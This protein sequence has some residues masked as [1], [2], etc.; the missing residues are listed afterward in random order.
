VVFRYNFDKKKYNIILYN[1]KGL[2]MKLKNIL[3]LFLLFIALGTKLYATPPVSIEMDKVNYTTE[4][5]PIVYLN[6]MLGDEEDWIA[7]YPKNSSNDWENVIYWDWTDGFINGSLSFER[8]PIGE[9]EARV[10]FKNS[11]R[12]E[13]KYAFNVLGSEAL[14]STD[15]NQYSVDEEINVHFEH[16]FGDTEDWI[17]I[18]PKGSSN[19]WENVLDWE[20]T[21]GLKN[22]QIAFDELPLCQYEV[23]TFYR[24]SYSVEAKYQFNVEPK[25]SIQTDKS[26]YITEEKIHITFEQMFG[27]SQDWIALY[28]KGSSNDWDNVISWN[29]TNGEKNGQLDFDVPPVGQYEIRA[30]F[31]NSYRVESN[32]SITVIDTENLLSIE[33]DKDEYNVSENIV[34]NFEYMQGDINQDWIAIYPKDSA[35]DGSNILLWAYTDGSVNG[36]VTLGKLPMGEYEARAFFHNSYNLEATYTFKVKHQEGNS[37]IYEDGENG[38]SPNWIHQAGD[39]APIH[40]DNDGFNSN[41]ALALV[42]QWVYNTTNLALYYL[43]LNNTTQKI[44]EMDIGGLSN[45]HIPNK[46]ANQIGYMSHFAIGVSIHTTDGKRRM[47]WDSFLNH[48]NV[49]AYRTTNEDGTNVWLYY[50]SP[51]EHVRGFFG[52]DIHQWDHFRV[53]I[54]TQLK[55]LEPDNEVISVDY[56]FLTG[57]FLDNIKLSSN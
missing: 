10:F 43:P 21:E 8:L 38:L 55:I 24:N 41:G 51:V 31:K 19:D 57:G 26:E 18:Y 23:R 50:P 28:P 9:Y 12:L 56:L 33:T 22:G 16:M 2:S 35:I 46:P 30:F 7:I 6:N 11:Y 15:K 53:D 36:S 42:T 13:A 20:Y 4:E 54:E 44:L 29:F 17:A 5:H 27:D 52:I 25:V 48:Q 14:I 40:V 37:T 39:Y 3:L 1:K 34:V 49:P 47:L 32:V 45:F